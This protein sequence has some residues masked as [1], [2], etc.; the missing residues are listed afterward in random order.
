[1]FIAETKPGERDQLY[2]VLWEDND[3]E[4]YE[5]DEF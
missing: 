4:D 5:E 1:M 2:H 3:E